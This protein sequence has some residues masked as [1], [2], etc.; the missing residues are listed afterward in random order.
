MNGRLPVALVLE[1]PLGVAQEDAEGRLVVAHAGGDGGGGG[2]AGQGR[3]GR[4]PPP[5]RVRDAASRE[6]ASVAPQQGRARFLLPEAGRVQQ[7]AAR[8]SRVSHQCRQ[9]IRPGSRRA[10]GRGYQEGLAHFSWRGVLC[11]RSVRRRGTQL[12][13]ISARGNN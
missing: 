11:G 8:Q 6:E 13:R 9:S 2:D 3:P 1:G 10:L 7:T 12:Q 4:Q 5:Q